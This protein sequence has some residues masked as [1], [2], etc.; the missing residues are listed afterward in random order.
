MIKRNIAKG[1]PIQYQKILFLADT[2]L[3]KVKK[4]QVHQNLP[5]TSEEAD[6][7]DF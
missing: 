6:Q 4:I 5:H 3:K 2:L 1:W 7:V